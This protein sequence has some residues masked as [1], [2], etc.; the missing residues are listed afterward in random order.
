[1]QILVVTL[2]ITF[3][4]ETQNK[5]M[6]NY[7]TYDSKHFSLFLTSKNPIYFILN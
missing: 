6:V 5:V 2:I 1:M 7:V 3:E 4:L